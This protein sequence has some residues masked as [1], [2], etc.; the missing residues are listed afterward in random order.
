MTGTRTLGQLPDD[1]AAR[2]GDREALVFGTHRISFRQLAAEIDRV[3]RGLLHLGVAP[4]ETVAIWLTNCP[5]W[6]Y[7]L[8]ACAKIGAVHVP[9]NTRLR[10]ADVEYVLRQSNTATLITHDVSAHRLPAMVR[11]LVPPRPGGRRP[12][13]AGPEAPTIGA[14]VRAGITPWAGCSTEPNTSATRRCV[15]ARAVKA[16]IP[17]SSCIVSGT[18]ASQGRGARPLLP[19]E[20]RR[21]P[22]APGR[23]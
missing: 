23:D 22:P 3:A 18:T 17:P 11:E 1:A 6:I 13:A 15:R 16:M 14:G 7:A 8:F 2:W 5:E 21:T 10:T 12:P 19:I 20:P 4:G 9:V